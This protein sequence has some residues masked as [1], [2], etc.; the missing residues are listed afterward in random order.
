M[1]RLVAL[2]IKGDAFLLQRDGFNILVD[3]GLN[4]NALP[5]FLASDMPKLKFIHIAVCTHS[6]SDHAN[7]FTELLDKWRPQKEGEPAPIGEFWLPGSWSAVV[8]DLMLEPSKFASQVFREMTSLFDLTIK[9][10]SAYVDQNT[11]DDF[12]PVIDATLENLNLD[13]YRRREIEMNEYFDKSENLR[14]VRR[15][16]RGALESLGMQRLR[17]R[18]HEIVDNEDEGNGEMQSIR[19]RISSIAEQG[20]RMETAV[21]EY[22]LD[23][24][25]AAQTIR[26]IALSAIKH[27]VKIRWFDYEEFIDRRRASGGIAGVLTPVNAVELRKGSLILQPPSGVML[28][29]MLRLTL[30]NRQC[31]S[32][33][34]RG[35]CCQPGVLFCGDSPMGYGSGHSIP[36]KFFR[37]GTVQS[38]IATAPH[39]GLESAKVAYENIHRQV[40]PLGIFWVRSGGTKRYPIGDSY[41]SI[42]SHCRICTWCPH[43][44]PKMKAAEIIQ[45]HSSWNYSYKR[46]GYVCNC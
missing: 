5:Q 36:F 42:S 28:S 38:I 33:Y 15:P 23:L 2:P 4:K 24:I 30:S 44:H 13:L 6:D 46:I 40:D 9:S 1:Q 37:Q 43:K 8:S 7:G 11:D 21:A 29:Y 39:H 34:S 18:S 26:S 20:S 19:N 31:L 14:Q 45:V 41:R 22:W 35:H 3:G 32:F 17:N 27:K 16:F 25:D 10:R 12:D